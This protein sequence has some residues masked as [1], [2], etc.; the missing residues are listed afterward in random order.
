MQEANDEEADV[1]DVTAAVVFGLESEG[2]MLSGDG[3]RP[4]VGD[5]LE[6]ER[7]LTPVKEVIRLERR[8]PPED[9]FFCLPSCPCV[10]TSLA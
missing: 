8:P 1:T 9:S 3:D 5:G 6:G 7:L 10:P 4:S 2:A